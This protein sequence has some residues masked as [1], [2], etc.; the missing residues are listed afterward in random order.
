VVDFFGQGLSWNT[1]AGAAQ[2]G[3]KKRTIDSKRAALM[4]PKK[5]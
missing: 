2:K 4:T 3:E 1:F 5:K